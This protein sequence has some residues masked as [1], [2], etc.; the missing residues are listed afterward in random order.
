MLGILRSLSC[1]SVLAISSLLRTSRGST[2]IRPV[3]DTLTFILSFDEFCFDWEF[4]GWS[5]VCL[6]MTEKF[7]CKSKQVQEVILNQI[8]IHHTGLARF[9]GF[10]DIEHAK[11]DIDPNKS[12]WVRTWSY[13]LLIVV[14]SNALVGSTCQVKRLH[15]SIVE[16]DLNLRIG[17]IESDG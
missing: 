2:L 14:L 10:F 3:I 11:T 5:S 9:Y 16:Q 7:S 6:D 8:L 4:F 12:P 17:W 1:S 15:T 13:R